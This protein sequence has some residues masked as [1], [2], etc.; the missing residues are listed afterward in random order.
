MEKVE[1]VKQKQNVVHPLPPPYWLK[2]SSP[3]EWWKG[4]Q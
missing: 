4:G 2:A 3:E 1:S